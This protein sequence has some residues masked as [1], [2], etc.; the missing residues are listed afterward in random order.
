MEGIPG[1]WE[2]DRIIISPGAVPRRGPMR[3]EQTSYLDVD[4]AVVGATVRLHGLITMW[5]TA[6]S[7]TVSHATRCI[8]PGSRCGLSLC[9][10][11][12]GERG[13]NPG[14]KI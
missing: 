3:L 5:S 11:N 12:P 6:K 14:R 13:R 4:M 10:V 9:R 7:G 8:C 2:T 1:L